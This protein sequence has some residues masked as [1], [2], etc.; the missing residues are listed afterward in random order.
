PA[1]AAPSP[2]PAAAAAVDQA[3]GSI[4]KE[5]FK[6]ANLWHDKFKPDLAKSTLRRILLTDPNNAEALYLLSMWSSETGDIEEAQKWRDRLAQVAPSD[7]RLQ[8]LED[9]KDLSNISKDQ[10]RRAR[11][12]AASGNIAGALSTYQTL[13]NGAN[14]PRGL[15]SEYYLTMSGD[16]SRYDEA[17]ARLVQYIRQNP[18]DAKAKLTYG[19]LLTYRENTRRDGIKVLEYYA[20][21][22]TDAQAALRQALI[23]LNPTEADAGYYQRYLAG[24]PTDQEVR[25]RFDDNVIGGMAAEAYNSLNNQNT[26]LAKSEFEAILKRDPNNFGAL[27]GLGYIYLNAKEYGQAATYLSRAAQV[28]PEQQ[29]RLTYDAMFASAHQAEKDGD[30]AL[31]QSVTDEMLKLT[32]VNLNDVHLFKA[33]IYKRQG[34][35]ERAEEQLLEVLRTEP[36][37]RP[38]NETLYYLYKNQ[39]KHDLAKALLDNMTPD[40]REAILKSSAGKPYVDPVAPIRKKAMAS[41]NAG[42]TQGAIEILREGLKKHPNSAWLRY[43]LARMLRRSGDEMGA[44]SQIMHLTRPGASNESLFAAATYQADNADSAVALQTIARIGSGYNPKAIA[45]LRQRLEFSEDLKRAESYIKS[46]NNA[47]ALNTLRN[48]KRPASALETFELG[49]L[50]RAYLR[51]GDRATALSL[52]DSA[53]ARGFG[54]SDAIGDYADIVSVYNACGELEKSRSI[55]QNAAI[56][57]NSSANDINRIE[58]GKVIEEADRLR[59]T[60]RSADAYDILYNELLSDPRDPDLMMAMARLYHDNKMYKEAANIYDRVLSENPGSE[61]AIRGGIDAALADRNPEKAEILASHLPDTADPQLLL[62]KARVASENKHYKSAISYLRQSKSLLEGTP[63]IGPNQHPNQQALHAHNNPFRNEHSV[64]RPAARH[65]AIMPWEFD[66]EEIN[67]SAREFLFDRQSAERAQTLREVNALLAQLYDQTSTYVKVEAQGRQ[68]DG[69]GGTSKVYEYNA[70]I[71][72]STSI[73]EDHRLTATITPNLMDTGSSSAS[74]RSQVGSSPLGSAMAS[75]GSK[76]NQ[77]LYHVQDAGSYSALAASTDSVKSTLAAAMDEGTFNSLLSLYNANGYLSNPD[78]QSLSGDL[79]SKYAQAIAAVGGQSGLVNAMMQLASSGSDFSFDRYHKRR[80]SGVAMSLGLG[81][82][83]YNIDIGITPIGKQG[84]TFVGGL[85]FTPRLTPNLGM[86]IFAERRALHDSLLSYY[87]LKDS[88]TGLEWGSV[89]KNGVGLRLNYDNGFLGV[90]GSAAYY[91]YR[92]EHTKKNDSVHLGLGTY[93]RPISTR[94]HELTAGID[95]QYMNYDNNQNHFSYGHGGYFSPKDYFAIALPVNYTR[96]YDSFHYHVGASIGYQSFVNDS[97]SFFPTEA[98]WQAGMD[99][100]AR[101]GFISN[102]RYSRETKS[103]I[104]GSATFDFKYNLNDVF[105]VGGKFNYNT[106]GDYK[107]ATEMLNFKYIL[108]VY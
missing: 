7:P 61:T 41:L 63:Y 83:L 16:P 73:F 102:S 26:A 49:Q 18:S 36:H 30:L 17:V 45:G 59:L 2:A 74:T 39:N 50:A 106:F 23:W 66:E 56:L 101:A 99:A 3:P 22:S 52:A 68:K 78:L 35:N 89:T 40:L 62:L 79:L 97:A 38:A 75:M 100:L 57:A 19:K 87:G 104:S 105:S 64:T 93:V 108:G 13:F 12:L 90:Y 14:P 47:A 76:F 46:G 37:N 20:K 65:A 25:K 94:E 27:E 60:G 6:Q 42:N 32:G 21:D 91:R 69:D 96:H 71:S 67:P 86:E 9:M 95:I 77:V 34:Q 31:A 84:T 44:Q 15:M 85:R 24:H 33:S 51:A 103:G 4:V 5:L 72:I 81:N 92:G 48:I 80:K 98:G 70:P 53:L 28:N 82:A 1:V 54:P 29:A 10:L 88:W 11:E 107:E 58:R 55:T 43:D 8:Q